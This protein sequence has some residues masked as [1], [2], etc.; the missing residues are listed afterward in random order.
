MLVL[1]G[2]HG[3]VAQV[4]QIRTFKDLFRSGRRRILTLAVRVDISPVI[5]E[6]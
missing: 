1:D 5:R 4:G 6:E 2:A 3:I